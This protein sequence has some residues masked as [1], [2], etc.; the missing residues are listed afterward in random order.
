[1]GAIFAGINLNDGFGGSSR[2][3]QNLIFNFCRESGDHGPLVKPSSLHL[4][5]YAQ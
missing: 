3:A 2:I 1:M 5:E 4:F